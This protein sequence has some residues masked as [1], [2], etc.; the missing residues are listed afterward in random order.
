MKKLLIGAL[1]GLTAAGALAAAAP[2]S[3]R[4]WDQNSYR[5]H[6][7]GAAVA[8]GIAGLAIGA[9]LASGD[10]GYYAP[11]P[12]YYGAPAPTYYG[13]P[14]PAYYA[15]PTYYSSY[16]RCHTQWRWSPYWRRYERVRA[17]Y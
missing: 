10:H 16:G 5:S 11:A 12:V 13:G 15:G 4:D 7:D 3:A 1:T 17:C 14:A 6:D 8:A 9:A 2:A